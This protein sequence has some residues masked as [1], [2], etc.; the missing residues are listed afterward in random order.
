MVCVKERRK[1]MA[2]SEKEGG[3]DEL[4]IDEG[5]AVGAERKNKD[6]TDE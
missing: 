5:N 6:Y 1:A 4:E 2:L 3:D